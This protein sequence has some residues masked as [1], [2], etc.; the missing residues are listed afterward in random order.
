MHDD[1]FEKLLASLSEA[2]ACDPLKPGEDGRVLFGLDS[3]MGVILY[4][5][6][7][8]EDEG[9]GVVASIVIGLAPMEN[10]EFLG[11]LL[12]AN[13]LWAGSGNGT[14]SVDPGTGYL[15]LHRDFEPEID[16]LDFVNEFSVMVGAARHWR[17]RLDTVQEDASVDMYAM[18]G[19][20]V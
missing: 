20:A 1:Y 2:L 16:P 3:Q 6:D 18:N 17:E 7:P 13:Y 19:L 4:A 11:E 8:E 10:A 14:L 5:T 15:C 9:E 12:R